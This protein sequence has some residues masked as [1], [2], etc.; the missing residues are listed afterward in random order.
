VSGIRGRGP[1]GGS[2]R[3]RTTTPQADEAH[4]F[5]PSR[6]RLAIPGWLR[7]TLFLSAPP[8]Q[9]AHPD[10]QLTEQAHHMARPARK[11][12]L[13]FLGP[14]GAALAAI[15]PGWM[16]RDASALDAAGAS[17]ST[18]VARSCRRFLPV[19]PRRREMVAVMLV[20]VVASFFSV[21]GPISGYGLSEPTP[22]YMLIGGD[23]TA[24]A[25]A[26]PLETPSPEASSSAPDQTI[27]PA[28]PTPTPTPKPTPKPKPLPTKKPAAKPP[29]VRTFVAL[30]D[31]LT[32]WPDTP[33]PSRL[34]SADTLLKL[35]NNAGVPG[36]T[37]EQMRVRMTADVY[38][39]NPDVLFVLGGTNDLGLGIS[40]SAT[41]ANLRAIIV[42]AKAH[43]ITV[44]LLL[45]PPDSYSSMAPKIDSLNTAI[46]NLARAQRV[47]Y[48][49]I[50]APLT[51]ANGVYYA[52]YTSDGL[53]FTDLGAQVVANTIR[54]RVK[55]LGF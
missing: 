54:A 35:V 27:P 13:G 4:R 42:G 47:T 9:M 29:K 41:I 6:R 5:G 36:N 45:V 8:R 1:S 28:T 30:G 7:A 26:T 2:V 23:T 24:D 52:K 17:I 3:D 46:V 22:V 40:G 31:S 32:A 16:H 55:L 18:R 19:E 12:S 37:T 25:T 34:D 21:T 43:K 49:N 38:A 51:N 53:H 33:W 14:L 15:T 48:V 39:Y 11:S 10:P 44:I 20:L 50:H